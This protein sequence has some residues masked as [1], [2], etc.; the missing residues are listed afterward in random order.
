MSL[1]DGSPYLEMYIFDHQR[2]CL[3]QKF[4]KSQTEIFVIMLSFLFLPLKIR[5]K[6]SVFSKYDFKLVTA[7]LQM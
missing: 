1:Y 3:L 4:D 6:F 5:A 7:N 2:W